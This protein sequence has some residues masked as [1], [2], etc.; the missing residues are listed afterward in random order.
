MSSRTQ[1][2]AARLDGPWL[3][4]DIFLANLSEEAARG[5]GLLHY[6]RDLLVQLVQVLLSTEALVTGRVGVEIC[7]LKTGGR[8]LED[9]REGGQRA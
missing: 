8:R 6:L 2:D 3:E 5:C 9:V 1:Q 4:A 7:G